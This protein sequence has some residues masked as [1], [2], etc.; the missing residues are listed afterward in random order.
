MASIPDSSSFGEILPLR[1]RIRVGGASEMCWSLF[2]S[3]G[4]L[5]R[6]AVRGYRESVEPGWWP[7]QVLKGF[8]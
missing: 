8:R 1:A 7:A 3:P 2:Q 4:A 6:P 5:Q